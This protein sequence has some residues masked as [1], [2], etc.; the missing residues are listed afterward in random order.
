MAVMFWLFIPA[1]IYVMISLLQYLWNTTMPQV[2]N[3]NKI[4]FWQAFRLI[5]IASILFGVFRFNFTL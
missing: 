3:L 1:L 5:L 4:T 2:F